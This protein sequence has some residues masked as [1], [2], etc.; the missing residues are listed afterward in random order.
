MK[1]AAKSTSRARKPAVAASSHALTVAKRA[2]KKTV[3]ASGRIGDV[4][5]RTARVLARNPFRTALGALAL[6]FVFAKL[7]TIF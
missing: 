5:N 4:K 7:K 1:T 2:G 3:A 6:G